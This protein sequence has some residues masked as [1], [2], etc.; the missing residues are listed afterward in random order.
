MFHFSVLASPRSVNI[1]FYFPFLLSPGGARVFF[2]HPPCGELAS[3]KRQE[4]RPG[5]KNGVTQG[6]SF[7]FLFPM[8]FGFFVRGNMG[9]LLVYYCIGVIILWIFL[10]G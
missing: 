5:W 4:L 1:L 2:S 9:V 6:L 8:G 7:R 3:E 10:E